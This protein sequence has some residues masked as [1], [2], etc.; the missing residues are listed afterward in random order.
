MPSRS[1]SR[2]IKNACTSGKGTIKN[3]AAVLSKVRSVRIK[4]WILGGSFRFS[5]K[6]NDPLNGTFYIFQIQSDG[7]LQARQLASRRVTR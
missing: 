6:S 7:T 5:T 3:R 2:A 1:C 4:D